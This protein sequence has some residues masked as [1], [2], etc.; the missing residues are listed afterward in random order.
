[1]SR[2][3]DRIGELIDK[4]QSGTAS[5]QELA[6]L[7]HW[8]ESFNG[9][10]TEL[11]HLT[12]Q[13]QS[14]L[15]QT[16]FAGIKVKIASHRLK[17]T[18]APKTF[19]IWGKIAVAAA[20]ATVIFRAGLFIYTKYE[21][22]GTSQTVTYGKDIAP[23]RQGATLTLSSGKK[24]RIAQASQG[25][26][27][28]EAGVSISK[29]GSGELQYEIK[30]DSDQGANN[31]F[32]TAKGETFKVKL[33]DGSQV[34]LNSASSLSYDVKLL[35]NGVRKVIM[36][37]EAYFEV[38]RDQQHPFIVET[39]DQQV[40]VLGTHFNINNYPDEQG[41]A[42]SLLEGSVKVT[43]NH[44]EQ[45]LKPGYQTLNT[46]D[47]LT[48][49]KVNT[50]NITDWKDGE[51]NLDGLDLK[52]A[53]RKIA[54]WYDIQVIYDPSVPDN[55]RPGGWISRDTKLSAVLELI[56]SS[57]QVRFRIEGRRLYVSR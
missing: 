30:A 18:K 48:T 16:L 28:S 38:A 51:F 12:A 54:R 10:S 14:E 49:R 29:T 26:L 39:A 5:S 37:G 24:I 47:A 32:E 3:N 33:P 53:M 46:G 45:I 34:W 15:R 4:F 55:L 42:T 6:E 52:T 35:K 50:D 13:D 20:I 21:K 40:Q 36:T 17:E 44:Q 11:Q 1:M 25:E 2:P 7:D 23:G 31:R 8:Y 41:T 27:A 43:A 56:Q 57:G 19:P 22:A 9:R